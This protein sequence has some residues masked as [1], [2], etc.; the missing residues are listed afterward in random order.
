MDG[1]NV[2]YCSLQRMS[3]VVLAVNFI[4]IHINIYFTL[5][6]GHFTK[7]VLIIYFTSNMEGLFKY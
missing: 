7:I 1:R 3:N 4:H 6:F 5:F 2:H